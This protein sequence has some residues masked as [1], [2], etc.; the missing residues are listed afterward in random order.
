MKSVDNRLK[1]CGWCGKVS[2]QY[3]E[4]CI[5]DDCAMKPCKTRDKNKNDLTEP[6]KY[7]MI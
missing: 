5:T 1:N 6:K 4:T 2:D 3:I 7:T